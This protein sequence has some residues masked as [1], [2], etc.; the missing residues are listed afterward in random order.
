MDVASVVV[1][2][3][4]VGIIVSLLMAIGT[5]KLHRMLIY[6]LLANMFL[7]AI[8]AFYG[9]GIV[10]ALILLTNAGVVAIMLFLAMIIGEVVEE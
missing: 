2:A 8:L 10:A 9:M 3:L 6:F 5:K 4:G 1:M 7:F